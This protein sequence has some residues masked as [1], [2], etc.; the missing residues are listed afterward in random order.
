MSQKMWLENNS[1]HHSKINLGEHSQNLLGT[2]ICFVFD[3]EHK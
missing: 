1:V 2:Q 3:I